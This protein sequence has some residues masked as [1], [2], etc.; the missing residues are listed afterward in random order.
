MKLSIRQINN[1]CT[2]IKLA[3]ELKSENPKSRKF[4]TVHGYSY[5]EEGKRIK[6]TNVLNN[7]VLN[8]IFFEL[9]YY[10]IPL[11]YYINRWDV[12]EDDLLNA[13]YKDDIKGIRE[14]EA[15]LP[16]YIQDFS[17]LKPEWYC[18]NLL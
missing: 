16:N 1:L 15:E 9:H 4:I 17:I 13:V 12:T 5:N 6:L 18:D 2:G 3:A 11:E 14:L 10:E 8:H 7:D